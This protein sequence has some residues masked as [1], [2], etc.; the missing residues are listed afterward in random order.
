M[1]KKPI[2]FFAGDAKK[3]IN[4]ETNAASSSSSTQSTTFQ[5]ENGNT[6]PSQSNVSSLRTT[7]LEAIRSI[8]NSDSAIM[9]SLKQSILELLL[10][11]RSIDD[12]QNDLFNALGVENFELISQILTQ[13]KEVIQAL[14]DLPVENGSS[15]GNNGTTM[16]DSRNIFPPAMDIDDGG[17]PV[18]NNFIVQTQSQAKQRKENR[19]DQKKAYREV[20]KVIV[21]LNET[22]KLDYQLAL[23]EHQKMKERQFT[24]VEYTTSGITTRP[25]N[26]PYV[27]D[28]FEAAGL[29]AISVDSTKL[30][31]PE[32][33]EFKKTKEYEEIRVP[34]TS[35]KIPIDVKRIQVKDLDPLGKLG[36]EGFKELNTIQSI[37]FEQAYHTV[38]NLLICAPTGAGKT[39]IAM[40]SVLKTI[41]DHCKSDGTIDKNDFK[42]IYI[43]PMKALA[44]EMTENF[45]KRLSKLGLKVRELTGDTTLT[46]KEIAETQMLVLTP[47]KWDVVTRKADDEELTSLVRLL[48]IDEVHL[49]HD[50]RGPVIETIVARTRRRIQMYQVKQIHFLI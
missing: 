12:L 14:I 29:K 15:S 21:G 17:N 49:L 50:D 46:K 38:E 26:L 42:I 4:G 18:T 2:N 13:R 31:L 45:S 24:E 37:V 23:R 8:S 10:S 19:K 6:L 39:N 1:S 5:A 20:N 44:A 47:E 48:I 11:E 33:T 32:G 35:Q 28:A 3:H 25:K 9:E 43:A 40:L 34:P 30:C 7:I 22:D 16:F 41:R 36:F 27:F